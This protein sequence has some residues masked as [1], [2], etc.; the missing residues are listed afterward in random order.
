V[1]GSAIYRVAAIT[2]TALVFAGF[3]RTFYL[4]AW[5]ASQ[6]LPTLYIAHGLVFTSWFVVLVGQVLLVANGRADL[7]RRL[8]VGG[9]IIALAMVVLGPLVAVDA[10]RHGMSLEFLLTPL[11]DV[12]VFAIL[13][14]TA[15][16]F[17]NRR[18]VHS[19]LVVVATVAILPPVIA[20]LPSSFFAGPLEVFGTTDLLLGIV[21]AYDT[22]ARRKLHP[23]YLWGGALLVASHPLR[24]V[25]ASTSTWLCIARWLVA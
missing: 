10:A 7:H 16:W 5:F 21:V 19:R 4:R 6:P 17:R 15:L 24:V 13:I 9:G 18:A 1:R 22:I 2:A 12:F 8:G 20:R 23:A 3:A 25:L 11:A 14:G